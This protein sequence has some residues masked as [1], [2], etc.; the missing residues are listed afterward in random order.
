MWIQYLKDIQVVRQGIVLQSYKQID[1]VQVFMIK[2]SE[3]F[4]DMT[5]SIKKETVKDIFAMI[6]EQCKG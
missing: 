4:N 6:Y 5:Y 2:S 1:P 3:I